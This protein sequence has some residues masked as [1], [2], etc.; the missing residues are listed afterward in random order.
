MGGISYSIYMVHS[1]VLVVLFSGS[2]V[3]ELA[4]SRHWLIHL[5]D[6]QA[7]FE[8]GASNNLMFLIY[9]SMTVA[10]AAF[11]WRFIER[12]GQRLF[13]SLVR[14]AEIRTQTT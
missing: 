4:M 12:P 8:L 9:L 3:T 2:E 5:K 11:T 6:G 10:L 1:L 7:I 13:G 14:P